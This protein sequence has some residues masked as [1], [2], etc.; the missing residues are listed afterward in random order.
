MDYFKMYVKKIE[1]DKQKFTAFINK[2]GFVENLGQPEYSDFRERVNN[3]TGLNQAMKADLCSCYTQM[4]SNL[5]L[6]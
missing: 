3:H 1:A 2:R 5:E 6:E 4:L